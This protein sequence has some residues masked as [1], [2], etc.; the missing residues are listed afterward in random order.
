MIEKETIEKLATL[1]RIALTSEE[2]ASF[3]KEIDSILAY[4]NQIQEVSGNTGANEREGVRNVMRD[5]SNPHESG[6]FTEDA[7]LSAPEK[8]R[9]LIKVKKII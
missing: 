4:V 2:K 6:I 8:E 5:D 1:A 7:V 3:V 9:N